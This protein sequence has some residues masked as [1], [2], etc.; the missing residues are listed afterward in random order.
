MQVCMF[1]PIIFG[2]LHWLLQA[3]R[4]FSPGFVQVH[5]VLGHA[6]WWHP[7]LHAGRSVGCALV[8]HFHPGKSRA[9][10]PF[11]H[12]V[13]LSS[14]ICCVA[15]CSCLPA[16]G[17]AHSQQCGSQYALIA[18][19]WLYMHD[20]RATVCAGCHNQRFASTDNHL[21]TAIACNLLH[22]SH[23]CKRAHMQAPMRAMSHAP[24]WL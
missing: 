3:A 18:A 22:P 1:Y 7:L 6:A 11:C 17:V 5:G 20:C 21:N 8:V 15:S 24:T 23:A 10:A 4:S 13:S 14:S 19:Y 12:D 2:R 9:C 16:E